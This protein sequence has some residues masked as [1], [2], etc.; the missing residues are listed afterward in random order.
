[1]EEH[2]LTDYETEIVRLTP[3][4][5]DG[6]AYFRDANKNKLYRRMKEKTPG[7]YVGRYDPFTET[8]VTD[9]PDSDDEE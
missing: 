2:S 6:C 1:M 4:T 9:V 5:L 8:L 3:F 7:P